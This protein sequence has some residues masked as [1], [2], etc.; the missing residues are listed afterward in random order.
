MSNMVFWFLAAVFAAGVGCF[1]YGIR[2]AVEIDP[3]EEF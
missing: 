3:T 2:N 1:A